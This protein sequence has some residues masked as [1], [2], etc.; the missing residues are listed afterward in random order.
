MKQR[1]LLLI[2]GVWLIHAGLVQAQEAENGDN[3]IPAREGIPAE[4]QAK[5][6]VPVNTAVIDQLGDD[7]QN[8]IKLLQNRFRIDHKVDEITMVLFRE[9]GS[10]PAVL[11]RPDGSKIYQSRAEEEGVIWYDDAT[12][13]MVTIKNPVPGPWQAVGQI[14]PESR[15]MVLSELR[16]HAEPLPQTIFSGEIVKQTAHLT[17]GDEPINQ[18]G[19]R[20]VVELDVEF[21]STNNP[22][23]D[24]FGAD[25]TIIATF[26]DNGKGMDERPRDGVFTGQFNLSVPAGE[27]TPVFRVTTP[28]YTRE[29]VDG[30]LMLFP[31]PVNLDV[32]LAQGE[33]NYHTLSIDV[34]REH[35][36]IQS[37]LVDGKIRYPNGDIQNF[38]LTEPSPSVRTQRILALDQGQFTVKLTVYGQTTNARDFILDVPA[39]TFEVLPPTPESMPADSQE[40]A[41]LP[42][43]ALAS[44]AVDT[45]PAPEPAEEKMATGT[46]ITLLIAVNTTILLVVSGVVWFIIR[47]RKMPA[48][49]QVSEHKEKMP[50]LKG[51][52]KRKPGTSEQG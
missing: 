37:I 34:N 24:N 8:S 4:A 13:D 46:L 41:Q 15:I 42:E 50:R 44:E 28:M 33:E 31:N 36:D 20:D 14:K 18:P 9:Y 43:P 11:V 48:G 25:N 23:Y 17:N 49:N 47:R 32:M 27:W 35:V 7:Y 6:K 52:F 3:A 5:E 29:Q 16:L 19:F 12:F 30:N 45:P 51:L 40:D 1:G 2:I 10:A 38:S 21:I 26:T 22:N 39:Y